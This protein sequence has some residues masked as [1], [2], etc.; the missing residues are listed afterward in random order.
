MRRGIARFGPLFCFA[1]VAAVAFA[2]WLL[3]GFPVPLPDAD[4]G[5]CAPPQSN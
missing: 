3:T 4:I 5:G 2:I 1:S